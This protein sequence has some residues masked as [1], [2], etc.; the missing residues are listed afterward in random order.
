MGLDEFTTLRKF[1]GG[2]DVWIGC[3]KQSSSLIVGLVG[4]LSRSTWLSS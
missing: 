1:L 3:G 4:A 2:E